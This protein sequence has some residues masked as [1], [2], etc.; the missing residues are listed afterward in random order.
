M[1]ASAAC[2]QRCHGAPICLRWR[3]AVDAALSIYACSLPPLQPMQQRICKGH[4]DAAHITQTLAAGGPEA[5]LLVWALNAK[6]EADPCPFTTK[7]LR[8][9][10]SRFIGNQTIIAAVR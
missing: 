2:C 8:E 6:F 7:A 9:E 1:P 10:F 5:R 4:Y 3:L